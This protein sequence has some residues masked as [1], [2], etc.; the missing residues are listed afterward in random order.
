MFYL[1]DQWCCYN[2]SII[3][4]IRIYLKLDPV[5]VSDNS[6]T[7]FISHSSYISIKNESAVDSHLLHVPVHI[8]KKKENKFTYVLKRIH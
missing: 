4:R 7:Q 6:L 2:I 8:K 3:N 5:T 1:Q